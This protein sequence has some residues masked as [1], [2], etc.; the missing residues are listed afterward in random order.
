MVN[1]SFQ[2]VDISLKLFGGERS[3]LAVELLEGQVVLFMFADTSPQATA[4][5]EIMNGAG[6]NLFLLI[7]VCVDLNVLRKVAFSY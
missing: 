7:L 1:I 2:K 4:T 6:V 5:Y 3:I